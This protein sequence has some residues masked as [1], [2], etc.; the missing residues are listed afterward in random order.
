MCFIL[1]TKEFFL[2]VK[3][4]TIKKFRIRFYITINKIFN[5]KTNTNKVRI[6][7]INKKKS[8]YI[9]ACEKFAK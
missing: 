4:S 1:Y 2:L 5:V 9:T 3:Y 7:G 6:S 8:G